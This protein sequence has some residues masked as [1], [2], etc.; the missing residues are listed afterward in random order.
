MEGL[1][2]VLLLVLPG[3]VDGLQDALTAV[4][5]LLLG[6]P[7]SHAIGADLG[8]AAW[9]RGGNPGERRGGHDGTIRLLELES[10][11]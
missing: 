9:R 4:G 7:A 10:G 2:I 3:R 11:S 1:A 6:T 8:R 5:E